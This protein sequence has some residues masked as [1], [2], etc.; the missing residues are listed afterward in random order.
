MRPMG[1]NSSSLYQ[2]FRARSSALDC[3]VWSRLA[4][5]LS[6]WRVAVVSSS[7]DLQLCKP[8]S[9]TSDSV[10]ALHGQHALLWAPQWLIGA[11]AFS[12]GGDGGRRSPE[13]L[14]QSAHVVCGG[15]RL[16]NNRDGP[17]GG[18][19][20]GMQRKS[21]ACERGLELRVRGLSLHRSSVSVR[22]FYGSRLWLPT[23]SAHRPRVC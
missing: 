18:V 10:L 20:S 17:T 5:V 11:V 22:P 23:L 19:P 1:P 14:A 13:Y 9:M 12:A 8:E 6:L 7:S 3:R 2:R 16:P 15:Q 21:P 4:L